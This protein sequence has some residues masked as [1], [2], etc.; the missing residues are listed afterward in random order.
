LVAREGGRGAG[1]VEGFGV[2]E[3]DVYH[4]CL[5]VVDRLGKRVLG[6]EWMFYVVGV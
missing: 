1:G 5:V 3:V 2:G 6:D 4:F